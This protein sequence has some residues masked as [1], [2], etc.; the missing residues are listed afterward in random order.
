ME[1]KI[2][3]LLCLLSAAA[4]SLACGCRWFDT[5]AQ[6]QQLYEQSDAVFVGQAFAAIG[7]RAP[8]RNRRWLGDDVLL[9][10]LAWKKGPSGRDTVAVMQADGNCTRAFVAG[11]TV[12]VFARTIRRVQG[13]SRHDPEHRYSCFDEEKQL[14]YKDGGPAAVKQ[15]RQWAR[16]FPAVHTTQCTS[17]TK[18]HRLVS[19]FFRARTD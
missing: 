12:Y 17:F 11:D 10:V 4:L 14:F 16:R 2:T 5:E 15:Y 18:Q 1:R 13:L 9:R 7:P 8:G 3:P 6:L 19:S